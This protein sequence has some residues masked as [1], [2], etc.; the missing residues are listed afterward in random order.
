MTG[1]IKKAVVTAEWKRDD[2]GN[3]ISA[4]IKNQQGTVFE[5]EC[6]GHET[7]PDTVVSTV[8]ASLLN[9]TVQNAVAY[10]SNFISF[11]LTLDSLD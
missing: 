8:I 5:F 4:V 11:T 1:P 9:V 7:R 2:N 10:S 6:A 3:I